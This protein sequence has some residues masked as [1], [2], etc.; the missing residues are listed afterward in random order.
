MKR[1]LIP[2]LAL[3]LM[4]GGALQAE[5]SGFDLSG[6]FAK[7]LDA[8]KTVTQNG[9]L[10]PHLSVGYNGNLATTTVPFR[11][12]L[13]YAAF[14]GKETE[15]TK[16]S[17]GLFQFGSDIFIESG[18]KGVRLTTGLTLNRW[19]SRAETGGT[20]VSTT[21]KGVKIGGRAGIDVTLAPRWSV[22]A[23]LQVAELGVDGEPLGP[24]RNP[25][26]LE[27]GA[28]YRF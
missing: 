25:A 13:G 8:M 3:C 15:G 21:V 27:L 28:R 17:L 22:N 26:W 14:N 6:G 11:L 7:P 16:R 4:G 2:A 10:A 5:G 19:T 23:T 12:S 18:F 24:S 9:A 1:K 20:S